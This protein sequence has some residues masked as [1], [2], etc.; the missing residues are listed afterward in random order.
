MK[1]YVIIFIYDT[2]AANNKS[3]TELYIENPLRKLQLYHNTKLYYLKANLNAID[4]LF[5]VTNNTLIKQKEFNFSEA[6]ELG[7][8]LKSIYDSNNKEDTTYFLLSIGHG[9]GFKP[10]NMQD[11]AKKILY[12]FNLHKAMGE[13]NFKIAIF[14]NCYTI[15]YDNCFIFSQKIEYLIGSESYVSYKLVNCEEIIT[16]IIEHALYSETDYHGLSCTIFDGIVVST[17]LQLHASPTNLENFNWSLF[18]LGSNFQFINR[19]L[20]S[21]LP[22]MKNAIVKD[23]KAYESLKRE[24]DINNKIGFPDYIDLIDFLEKW[25]IYF[26]DNLHA[27]NVIKVLRN[28]IRQQILKNKK[29]VKSNTTKF[30]G[31]SVYLP[32]YGFSVN[33]K[34]IVYAENYRHFFDKNRPEWYT[35]ISE[36]AEIT[37]HTNKNLPIVRRFLNKML[38]TFKYN[39]AKSRLFRP[40][41]S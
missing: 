6:E 3:Y 24:L 37:K 11:S 33:E 36:I 8:C 18:R 29:F 26:P 41:G 22:I 30:N 28:S 21:L 14:A 23:L 32:E 5:E 34:V 10:I 20:N 27:M 31:I 7:T 9:N 12:N 1:N 4:E 16:A 17:E 39:V 40:F 19:K 2:A 35:F 13:I 15:L 25:Q 38:A